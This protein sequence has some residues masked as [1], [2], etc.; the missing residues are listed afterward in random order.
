M[1][2]D[3]NYKLPAGYTIKDVPT[4]EF[5]KMWEKPGK[6]I[7]VDESLMFDNKDVFSKKELA[8]FQ[9]LREQFDTRNHHRVNLGLFHKG[10]FVGWS[11]GFQEMPTFFYMC[12]SAILPEHRGRGLYTC[13]MREMLKRTVEKGYSKI[14]SRHMITNNSIIIAKLKQG[15]KITSFELSDV[16]G[17]M[18]HLTYYPSALKNEILD[19][20]SGHKRPNQ[21]IKKIFKLA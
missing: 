17:T 2:K 13:L 9:K 7:F 18:V 20:R 12:N 5:M 11:W 10:K 3:F 21:K 8:A 15:F 1:N 16:F 4:E 6:K 14:Y 19:F